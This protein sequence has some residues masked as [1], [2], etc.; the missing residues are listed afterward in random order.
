MIIINN[1]RLEERGGFLFRNTKRDELL[2]GLQ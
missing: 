1:Y 2:S